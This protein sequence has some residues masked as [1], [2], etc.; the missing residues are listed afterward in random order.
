MK[1]KNK[2]LK[3]L[4]LPILGS[5]LLL[6]SCQNNSS[7][8]ADK[9]TVIFWHTF[10]QDIAIQVESKA[11]DFEELYFENTGE[12]INIEL[13]YQGGYDD[14]LTK[15]GN[16]LAV[17][18]VPTLAVAYPDHVADYLSKETDELTWVYNLEE[19]FNDSEIGFDKQEWIN[20]SLKG[21]DDFVPSFIEEGQNYIK[22]GTYS[23]PLM[24]SSEILLYNKDVLTLVLRDYD[25]SISDV[26]SYMNS[27]TWDEFINL[28]RFIAQD[29]N[30]YGSNLIIPFIYDSDENL[31]ISQCYQRGIPYV[32]LNNGKGSID[33]N[34][35]QAKAMVEELKG[36]FDEGLLLT[37]GTNNN[38]YG[39]D[40]FTRYECIF[41]VGSTGGTGYNDPG[42]AGFEV[43]VAKV[44]PVNIDESLNKYVSQGIT[45]TILRNNRL[46][47]EVND[48]RA[49]LAWQF[50]KY[51]TNEENNIDICL[52]SNGYSPV[53]E[54]CYE[55]EVYASYLTEQDFMPRVAN[56]VANE[57]NGEYF[58]YPV[59]QGTATARTQ[60]GGI[61]TQV[62]LGF[63]DIDTAFEDAFNL[64]LIAM[65]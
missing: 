46:N 54:S 47:E 27:I 6:S 39:S 59:F 64:S 8:N 43:G 63:K 7:G 37:K 61:I 44:P 57:I 4:F 17:G 16:G 34:N 41:T 22:D 24:K 15:I 30:K 28:L 35:D 51:L 20:P 13:E 10:G 56:V 49:R 11:E 42:A 21:V 18:N 12:E 65:N 29:L 2:L 26:D 38:E 36:Y 45:L 14:I 3:I 52:S 31:F 53:R 55:N 5:S 25:P 50:M 60:V 32:S 48:A 33:F 9:N 23:L 19:F 40:S 58:N 1:I 62:F